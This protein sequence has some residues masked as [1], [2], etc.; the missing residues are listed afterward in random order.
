[1]RRPHEVLGV[2]ADATPAQIR[3]AYKTR[4]FDL[5][6]DRVKGKEAE[7]QE[8]QRAYRTLTKGDEPSVSVVS[9]QFVVNLAAKMSPVLNDAVDAGAR[10][11]NER[12]GKMTGKAVMLTRDKLKEL[13]APHWVCDSMDTRKALGWEPKVKWAEGTK[14]A[15]AWYRE[16]GWL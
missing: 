12:I 4:A 2:A 11:V 6:P 3:T 15:A 13:S 14:R 10:M 1:M 9:D 5:H 8:L 7:W 16:H